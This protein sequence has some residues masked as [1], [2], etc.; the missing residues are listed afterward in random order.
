[1]FTSVCRAPVERNTSE[2]L[3]AEFISQHASRELYDDTDHVTLVCVR[4]KHLR[5]DSLV[6]FVK[7]S[8]DPKKPIR[9]VFSGEEAVDD[10]GPRRKYFRLLCNAI[11]SLGPTL[12][13]HVI[14]A[15]VAS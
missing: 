6:Q 15:C 7:A 12:I 3:L 1:M 13:F 9:V 5:A 4:T 10:G 14:I 11:N 8:F 2:L